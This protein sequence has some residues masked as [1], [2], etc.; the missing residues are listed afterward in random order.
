M[1]HSLFLVSVG[2]FLLFSGCRG[3]KTETPE[4][5]REPVTVQ[6]E[7]IMTVG[8]AVERD[9]RSV[10]LVPSSALFMRGQLEGVQ[11][12]DSES[13]LSIRW[14]RSGNVFGESVEVLSGL[15]VGER[16]VVPYDATAREGNTVTD[17]Q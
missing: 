10:L 4:A 14:I 2:F 16:I 6:V 13:V 1:K 11:I 8:S 12:V 3:N 17:K 9:G 5:G 7:S 15:E